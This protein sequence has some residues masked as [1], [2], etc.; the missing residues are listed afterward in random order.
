[1]SL[2][3][4]TKGNIKNPANKNVPMYNSCHL[5]LQYV[6]FHNL[7]HKC[8]SLSLYCLELAFSYSF[9]A[10]SNLLLQVLIHFKDIQATWNPNCPLCIRTWS[11]VILITKTPFSFDLDSSTT[12]LTM[13]LMSSSCSSHYRSECC[14]CVST[15]IT[16]LIKKTFMIWEGKKKNHASDMHQS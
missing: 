5:W 10:D 1:M 13:T 8:T 16:K 3:W 7:T 11:E 6:L 2:N 4:R 14:T 15:F 12:F 9:C